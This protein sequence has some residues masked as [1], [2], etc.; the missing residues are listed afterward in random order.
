MDIL[1]YAMGLIGNVGFGAACIPMAWKAYRS[2]RNEGIPVSAIWMFLIAL[3]N[4][5]GY[6]TLKHGYDPLV[7]L[8]G[9]VEITSWLTVWRYH[10]FPR[11]EVVGISSCGTALY[12]EDLPFEQRIDRA[13]Q[14][15]EQAR[16]PTAMEF[17][18]K[19]D[20]DRH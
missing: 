2:G 13:V 7:T 8:I 10:Y 14:R 5:Y 17:E 18:R 1:V 12:E 4:F 19:W 16:K 3:S 11:R 9:V 15:R 20:E 6:L